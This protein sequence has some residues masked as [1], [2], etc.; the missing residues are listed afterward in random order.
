M[1][2]GKS[3]LYKI[4]NPRRGAAMLDVAQGLED[5]AW[6]LPSPTD[7]KSPYG[8]PYWIVKSATA[9]FYGKNPSG[10]ANVAGIDTSAADAAGYR[11]YTDVFSAWSRADFILKSRRVLRHINWKSPVNIEQARKVGNKMTIYTSETGIE[12]VEMLAEDRAENLQRD[13]YTMDGAMTIKGHPYRYLP[14]LDADTDVPFYHVNHDSFYPVVL[15]G[16][17][18]REGKPKA[19]DGS[20]DGQHNTFV[21]WVDCSYNYLCIDRRSNAVIYKA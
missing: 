15:K 10:Y 8:V 18:L 3:L 7:R 4:I 6:T 17:W 14:K 19:M 20:P 9:G 16:D 21:V 2:R 5:D 1:N 11:N 13:L 12:N